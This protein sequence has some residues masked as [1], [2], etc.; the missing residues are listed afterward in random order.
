MRKNYIIF[1]AFLAAGIA[2]RMISLNQLD[3]FFGANLHVDEITY[4]AGD[5][6]PFERPPGTYLLA[7]IPVEA[8]VLRF[9]F[10]VISLVPAVA[11]FMFRKK[12]SGNAILAGILAVEPTLAFS[13][14]QI[15]P[16]APAAALLALALTAGR[17]R[18]LLLGWL[19][20]CGALFRGELL[21]FLPVSVFFIHPLKRYLTTGSGILI[22]VLPVLAINVIAGGPFALG[23]NGP[24]NLWLGSS[25]ELLETPPGIEFEEIMGD[26][27]FTDNSLTSIKGDI[28]GWFGRGFVKTAAFLSV[29]G[30]GRNIEAPELLSSTILKY[31]LALT[32]LIMAM[33]FSGAGKNSRTALVATG[34]VAAF[35]FFPSIR[36]RAVFLPALVL[37]IPDFRWKLAIPV[38]L[39]ITAFSLFLN[40]PGGVRPGL[41]HVQIAQDQLE[42]GEFQS[43]L[44][45]LITAEEEGFKGADIHTIRGACIASS[46]G[47]FQ[48]AAR[49]FGIALEMVPDSPTAWKNMAALLWNYGHADDAV[50]AA[51]KAVGLNPQLEFELSPILY[52]QR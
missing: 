47:D 2:I 18:P 4:V 5:S 23:E 49:E 29:P 26:D 41:T 28:P 52:G 3:W 19:I 11:L 50:Y 27:S 7:G 48:L 40:Y 6:P 32:L 43:A 30:P 39:V 13:G 24:M 12:S 36:H 45:E 22:A 16:A 46:G 34:L 33:G 44:E 31:L 37:S 14:L 10:S 25:W 42:S 35:I 38:A 51:E 9:I 21:L 8:S 17:D 20:G 15:L 1:F